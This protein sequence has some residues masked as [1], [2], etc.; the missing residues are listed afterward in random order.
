VDDAEKE[1]P[2]SR[3]LTGWLRSAVGTMVRVAL[4]NN[5]EDFEE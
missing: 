2:Y 3:G 5:V 4:K 1:A